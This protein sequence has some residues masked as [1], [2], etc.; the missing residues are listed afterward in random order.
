VSDGV[1][2][3]AAV[4]VFIDIGVPPEAVLF[5]PVWVLVDIEVLVSANT[6]ATGSAKSE[7]II[8]KAHSFPLKPIVRTILLSTFLWWEDII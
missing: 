8:R 2:V 3:V 1:V 5:V 6:G 4:D 7:Q